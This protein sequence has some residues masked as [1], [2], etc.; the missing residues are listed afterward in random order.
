MKL[1]KVSYTDFVVWSNQQALRQRIF[2][3]TDFIESA[4][5]KVELFVKQCILPELISKWFT[6]PNS[7]SQE[8]NSATPVTFKSIQDEPHISANTTENTPDTHA[9]DSQDWSI[10]DDTHSFDHDNAL[11]T[12]SCE[13]S[14]QNSSLTGTT[15]LWCY[16]KQDESFDYM[17]GCNNQDCPI[18]WF[19]L[20]CAQI[21]MEEV[22]EGEWFCPECQQC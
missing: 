4:L 10:S 9:T 7:S 14:S 17:T 20:S 5:T 2:F 22:P 18:Q 15:G 21:R 8:I 13:E 16:C 6:N 1:C 3:D 19:H 11:L 12:S